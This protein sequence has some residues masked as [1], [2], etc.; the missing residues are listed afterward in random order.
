MK[1]LGYAFLWRA[2]ALD[3]GLSEM[4]AKWFGSRKEAVKWGYVARKWPGVT[5]VCVNKH[6]NVFRN[7][8]AP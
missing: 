2:V 4:S 7:I 5:L 3:S 8:K 6:K 1:E